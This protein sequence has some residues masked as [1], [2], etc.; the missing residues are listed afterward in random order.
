M[1]GGQTH[2]S[3]TDNNSIHLGGVIK[4]GGG[5]SIG[6]SLGNQG[7]KFDDDSNATGP[8]TG[9]NV[10][11]KGVPMMLMNLEDIFDED[12]EEDV[13][14][15]DEDEVEAVEIDEEDLMNLINFGGL[16]NK[17]QEAIKVGKD[18]IQTGKDVR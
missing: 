9:V 16:K 3:Q 14:S 1:A 13:D 15:E 10:D 7:T 4:N 18:V 8:Q 12:S 11:L 2:S 6:G 17:A 5:I